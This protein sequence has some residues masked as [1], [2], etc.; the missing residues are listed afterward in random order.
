MFTVLYT[1]SPSGFNTFPTIYTFSMA[2]ALIISMV[3][4]KLINDI[5]SLTP[6]KFQFQFLSPIDY[7]LARPNGLKVTNLEATVTEMSGRLAE[8]AQQAEQLKQQLAEKDALL[9]QLE[10]TRAELDQNRGNLV[11]VQGALTDSRVEMKRLRT[12]LKRSFAD[13]FNE[14]QTIREQHRA[15]EDTLEAAL[16]AN[17]AEKDALDKEYRQLSGQVSLIEARNNLHYKKL[18]D[19]VASLDDHKKQLE[20]V[21]IHRK[22]LY[23]SLKEHKKQLEQ[24]GKDREKMSS[25]IEVVTKERDMYR[26]QEEEVRQ[27]LEAETGNDDGRVAEEARQAAQKASLARRIAEKKALDLAVKLQ[28][29]TAKITENSSQLQKASEFIANLRAECS[30]A[31]KER[32]EFEKQVQVLRAPL[33]A[34][35]QYSPSKSTKKAERHAK[36]ETPREAI[37]SAALPASVSIQSDFVDKENARC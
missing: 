7:C 8:S 36:G 15:S 31:K 16:A 22:K 14:L 26:D 25:V 33:S 27:K 12:N 37:S 23:D 3:I 29:A 11:T 1:I 19:A 35:T 20:R 34:P 28:I 30:A 10:A 9:S 24:A 5:A 17:A 4:F 6:L 32:D 18:D 21:K 13:H 2:V